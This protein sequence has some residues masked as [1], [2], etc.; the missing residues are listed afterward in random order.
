MTNNKSELKMPTIAGEMTWNCKILPGANAGN[1]ATNN[2][3]SSSHIEF[4]TANPTHVQINLL[5][6]FKSY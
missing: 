2:L 4:Y 6:I 1:H 5:Q 3:E